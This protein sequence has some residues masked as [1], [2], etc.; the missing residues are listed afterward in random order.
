MDNETMVN[1]PLKV[2][3]K[4]KLTPVFEMIEEASKTYFKNIKKFIEI[5]LRG[6]VGFIPFAA[7]GL[8]FI[9]LTSL[10][11]VL[12]NIVVRTVMVLLVFIAGVWAIY[13]GI[14]VRAAMKIIIIP[15]KIASKTAKSF[16]GATFGS[17]F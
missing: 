2:I 5:Y 7:L 11:S 15:L 9:L 17:Q 16:F 12:D 14:R 1:K 10:S 4:T 3:T 6:L 13:Y 8:L